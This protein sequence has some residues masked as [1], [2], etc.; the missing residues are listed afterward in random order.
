[1]RNKPLHLAGR[2]A[3]LGAFAASMAGAGR[4]RAQDCSTY[5]KPV[6]IVG[7]SAVQTFVQT[8]AGAL[9]ALPDPITVMYLPPGSCAGYQSIIPDNGDIQFPLGG[10]SPGTW[11][12]GAKTANYLQV[13]DATG[14]A[15]PNCTLPVDAP[16]DADIAIADV[17]PA[18][19][20]VAVPS[21]MKE[22]RGPVQSMTFGVY[23]DSI[24]HVMSGEAAYLTFGLGADGG[25]P[26]NDASHIWIRDQFSGTQQMISAAIGV[27]A[28]SWVNTGTANSTSGGGIITALQA[29]V[30]DQDLIDK[31]I[32]ILGMDAIRGN[33]AGDVVPLAYQHF[34]QTAGY[35]PSSSLGSNDMQ[36]TRD[37]HYMIQGPVHMVTRVSN[38]N[39]V[40]P[41]AKILIDY[42]TG[43][44]EPE[45]FDLIQLEANKSIVPDCAMRVTRD[46]D[47]GPFMSYLPD[48]SCECKF[49]KAATQDVPA[50]CTQC[51]SDDDCGSDRPVCNYGY[52]EVQ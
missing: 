45:T 25:T 41:N 11:N 50:E 29:T 24:Y 30:G 22:Y 21:G 19:C 12:A 48:H 47:A 46:E 42:L 49:L 17:F 52:C 31:S 32:G 20:G 9:A 26:W 40:N 8:V 44:T 28:T 35:Y 3:A 14:T 4:A 1:M 15:L 2:L 38:G 7:S 16:I 39:P 6:V 18:T 27:P 43:A 5:P 37:G 33:A 13:W 10:Q 23:K 34:G 51:G 36:N